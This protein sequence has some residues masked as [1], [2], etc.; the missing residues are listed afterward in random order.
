MRPLKQDL[1]I[2][3]K[4]DFERQPVGVAFLSEKP[5]GIT[6][7]D[8]TLSFCEMVKEAQERDAPFYMSKENEDCFGAVILGMMEPIILNIK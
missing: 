1:S 8:K 2:Y 5:E 4:F 7:L 3:R 6:P